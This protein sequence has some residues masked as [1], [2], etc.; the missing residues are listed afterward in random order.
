MGEHNLHKG[1][2]T[3]FHF[4]QGIFYSDLYIVFK[5]VSSDCNIGKQTLLHFGRRKGV[6]KLML[7]TKYK[8][9]C[10]VASKLQKR[11]APGLKADTVI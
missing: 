1:K 2:K 3:D 7:Y 10:A 11:S 4:I 5:L 8:Q 6:S 9:A